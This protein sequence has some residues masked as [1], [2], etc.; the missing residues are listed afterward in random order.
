M[1]KQNRNYPVEDSEVVNIDAERQ[2]VQRPAKSI[3]GTVSCE[4]LRIRKEPSSDAEVLTIIE[5]GTT[6]SVQFTDDN[7]W[8]RVKSGNTVGFVMAEFVNI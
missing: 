1:A 7:N 3:K 6:L 2:N 5:Q 8:F 4:K